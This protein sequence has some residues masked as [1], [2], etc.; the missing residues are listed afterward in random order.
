MAEWEEKPDISADRSID[1]IRLMMSLSLIAGAAHVTH[2]SDNG[3][4]FLRCSCKS[5]HCDSELAILFFLNLTHTF[6]KNCNLDFDF[7]ANK[8]KTLV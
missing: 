3:F 8:D 2:N 5:G 7:V 4:V 6:L 1:L